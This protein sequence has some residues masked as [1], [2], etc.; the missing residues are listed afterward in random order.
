M[1]GHLAVG[2]RPC[3]GPLVPREDLKAGMVSGLE[4]PRGDD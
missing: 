4:A 1:L 2:R 3:E